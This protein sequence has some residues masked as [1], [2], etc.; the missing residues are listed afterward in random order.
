[1]NIISVLSILPLVFMCYIQFV[2]VA[3][4]TFKSSKDER[5]DLNAK[6]NNEH[7]LDGLIGIVDGFAALW[8]VASLVYLHNYNVDAWHNAEAFFTIKAVAAVWL[9]VW[10]FKHNHLG[11]K[12]KTTNKE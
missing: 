8:W 7:C 4:P 1:M 10:L 6:L 11:L 9:V 5:M 2:K 12:K 3:V